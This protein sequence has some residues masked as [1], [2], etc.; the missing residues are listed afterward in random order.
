M[1]VLERNARVLEAGADVRESL[2][3]VLEPLVLHLHL[4]PEHRLHV[5]ELVG[6]LY[7]GVQAVLQVSGRLRFEA[8][9]VVA[10]ILDD[11]VEL[12]LKIG[13]ATILESDGGCEGRGHIADHLRFGNRGAEVVDPIP[14]CAV[15]HRL[16]VQLLGDVPEHLDAGLERGLVVEVGGLAGELDRFTEVRLELGEGHFVSTSEDAL[17]LQLGSDVGQLVV[18]FPQLVQLELRAESALD[19]LE[20]GHA[21][22]QRRVPIRQLDHLVERLGH[23]AHDPILQFGVVALQRARGV[24][25]GLAVELD[26]R[27]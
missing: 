3:D 6:Q 14:Q 2:V 27:P 15:Q 23:V 19:V 10:E 16:V 11:S 26:A 12:V 22:A 25:Q 4:L 7:V 9:G 18:E 13:P 20:L 1:A 21:R 8:G 24:L 5:L 17:V